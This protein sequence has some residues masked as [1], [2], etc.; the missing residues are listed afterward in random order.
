MKKIITFLVALVFY[1]GATNLMI[2]EAHH[3]G[4]VKGTERHISKVRPNPTTPNDRTVLEFNNPHKTQHRLE[5]YNIIGNKVGMYN[6]IYE[7]NIEINVEK[8]DGGMY[9]YFIFEEGER[10]SSGR[11]IVKR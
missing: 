2:A 6:D 8:L 7:D 1:T 9:F 5:I 11:L 10:I 3:S 4:G